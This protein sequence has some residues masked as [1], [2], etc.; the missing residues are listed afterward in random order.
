MT[1]NTINKWEI[2]IHDGMNKEMLQIVMLVI[3]LTTYI[4][5]HLKY[6]I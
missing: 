5:M 3:I 2:F 6:V 4:Q 1:T